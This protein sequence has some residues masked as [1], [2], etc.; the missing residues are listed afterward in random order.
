M[1]SFPRQRARTRN[2]TCGVPRG[3]RVDPTGQQVLFLRSP[4]GDDPVAGLWRYDIRSAEEQLLVDPHGLTEGEELP[5]E[6]RHRRE[7]VR[8]LGAGIVSI[9]TDDEFTVA[10]FVV[11]GQLHTIDLPSGNLQH[12]S[13]TG[14]GYDPRPDPAGDRIAYVVQGALHVL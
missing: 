1:R 11:G 2:F 4:S 3:F 14:H 9:A 12:R 8:E 6:E 5:V 10:A 7:R 13:T